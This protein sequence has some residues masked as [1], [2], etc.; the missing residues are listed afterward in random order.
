MVHHRYRVGWNEKPMQADH[1]PEVMEALCK[2]CHDK[3]HRAELIYR[4][5]ES[6]KKQEQTSER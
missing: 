3:E 2:S 1:R 4:L 5:K 6:A